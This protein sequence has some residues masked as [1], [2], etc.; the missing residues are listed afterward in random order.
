MPKRLVFVLSFSLSALCLFAGAVVPSSSY[1]EPAGAYEQE[2]QYQG[3]GEEQYRSPP[4][5]ASAYA[6]MQAKAQ[7][8]HCPYCKQAV[9]AV[10]QVRDV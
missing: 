2:Y 3:Q 7:L 10:V 1:A 4:A 8:K 6:Q 5:S 9:S